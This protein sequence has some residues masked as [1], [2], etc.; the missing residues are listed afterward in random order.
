MLMVFENLLNPIFNPILILPPVLSILIVSLFLTLITTLAYK[1]L[2]DQTR[3]KELRDEMKKYQ[4]KIKALTKENPEKAMKM[5]Q[6][7]MGKNMELMKHSFKPM[8]YTFLPLI[9]IFGWLNAHMAY[10]PLEPNDPFEVLVEFEDGTNGEVVF[11]S[12]PGLSVAKEN[13][14]TQTINNDK[15]KWV[16]KGDAGEYTLKFELDNVFVTK[17]ILITHERKYLEPESKFSDDEPFKKLTVSNEKIR[18][19][20]G[21]P[22][23]GGFGWLGAYIIFS[24]IG[25]FALRKLLKVA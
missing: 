11:S 8:I 5:Q 24:F 14:A 7:M 12:I 3:M 25:S 20:A 1:Y 2:T 9:I 19:F 17:D 18:P 4:A 21:A 15:A 22:L 23:I 6:E 10:L 16:L 13:G